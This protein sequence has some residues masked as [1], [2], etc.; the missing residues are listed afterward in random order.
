MPDREY[1]HTPADSRRRGMPAIGLR[2]RVPEHVSLHA[3]SHGATVVHGEEKHADGTLVG[4]IEVAVAKVSLIIDRDGALERLLD[5]TIDRLLAPPAAGRTL[6]M[7]PIELA[8]GPSGVM[9]EVELARHATGVRPALPCYELYALAPSDLAINAALIVTVRSV[10]HDW[11]AA[12]RMLES[13]RILTPR[14]ATG[15]P[16]AGD[17]ARIAFPVARRR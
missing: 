3:V 4:A 9:A 1:V 12:A 2:L 8:G 11:D 15:E 10:V 5:T 17:A 6:T 14:N 7:V 13:L 16:E